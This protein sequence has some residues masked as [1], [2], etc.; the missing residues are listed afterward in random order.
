M[1]QDTYDISGRQEGKPL[2]IMIEFSLEQPRGGVQFVI[3]PGS[4]PEAMV[5]VC[6][7]VCMR[8][9]VS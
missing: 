8:A 9:C 4:S 2:R 7:C 3:P 5:S 1:S 6:V